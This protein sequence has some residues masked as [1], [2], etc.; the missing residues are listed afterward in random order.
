[1]NL[2]RHLHIIDF[3]VP[4]P[5]DYGGVIDLF[6]KLPALQA[7]GIAIHLH[8]FDYGRG[9]Q[10]E[11]NKYCHSVHYYER[12]EGAR[13]I[14]A[15]LPYIV[16]TRCSEALLR[17]LLQDEY[18]ILM[19]GVHCT[20]LLNDT[21]FNNRKTYLRLHNVEYE[22]YHDLYK[23]TGSLFKKLYFL[24]EYKQLKHYEEQ[25][26][27][28]ATHIF[29][30]TEK[31]AATYRKT[32]GLRNISFLPLFL[33]EQWQVNISEGNGSFC[34]Y[35]GDLSVT[36]NEKA[37]VWLIKKVFA[38]L[39][40][41]LI[42]AGKKPS[43]KL[44]HYAEKYKHIH[45]VANPNEPAMQDLVAK[46]HIHILPSYSNTGIK[47]KLLNA[48]FNGRHC[49]ANDNTIA[50]SDMHE[51]CQV[52]NTA[53]EFKQQVQALYTQPFTAEMATKRKAALQTLFNNAG[54]AAKLIDVIYGN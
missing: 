36:A 17:N 40:I 43:K 10:P 54:N 9:Q 22:Y 16:S 53:E 3:T 2:E 34:L 18:P 13:A 26:A 46:A 24:A 35:Q 51:L 52:C 5:A 48:L 11:L 44:L 12:R 32:F 49:I 19:E 38:G 29:S 15:K 21:R 41:P 50:G 30:V 28:K 39:D 31:D 47:L 4:Y 8:C 6:W 23:H 14:S 33:P 42:I 1:M 45:L 20:Y 25:A 7:A 37:A 27:V